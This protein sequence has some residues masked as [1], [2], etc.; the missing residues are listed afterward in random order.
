MTGEA[1]SSMIGMH[2]GDL[3]TAFRQHLA[4]RS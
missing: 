2:W 1:L 3:A 4:K